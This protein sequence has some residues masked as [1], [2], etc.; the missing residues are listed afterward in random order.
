[1]NLT[2][3]YK[4]TLR[5]L[6]EKLVRELRELGNGL[7]SLI[8]YGSVARRDFHPE[9]DIDILVILEDKKLE[10]KA[11]DISYEIDL[12]NNT[13]T[14]MFL[15]TPEEI[16][17]YLRRGSPFLENVLREGKVLYDNGT[18]ERV[19]GSLASESR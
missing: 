18:W 16:E 9:S 7:D 15:S 3:N 6:K 4:E 10:E 13:F 11:S 19:R 12:K 2:R 5:D 17:R 8:L 14:T 1:M